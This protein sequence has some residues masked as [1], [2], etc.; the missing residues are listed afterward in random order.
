LF[1][2][3]PIGEAMVTPEHAAKLSDALARVAASTLL[4][5][6]VLDDNDDHQNAN[7]LLLWVGERGGLTNVDEIWAYQVYSMVPG[8]VLV[9]LG[10]FA[11]AKAQA[12]RL[13][14]SQSAIRDWATFALGLNAV[15]ARFTPRS[16]NDPHVEAFLALPMDH[17]LDVVRTFC[18]DARAGR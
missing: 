5:P 3:L 10:E 2:D 17:Y 7:A 13:Y 8:N 1:L 18:G 6:F 4:C 12:I 15:N 16:C 9:P 11:A 14:A